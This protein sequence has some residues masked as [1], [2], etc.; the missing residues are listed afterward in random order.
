MKAELIDPEQ[1]RLLLEQLPAIVWST[2]REL[3]L[4]TSL[5]AGLSVLGLVPNQVLG[6]SLFE[7]FGTQDRDFPPI[8]AHLQALEG[9]PVHTEVEW[10]GRCYE[11]YVEPLRGTGR[12]ILGVI[13]VALDV[14]QRKRAELLQKALYR[15]SETAATAQDMPAFYAALHAIVGELMYARNFYI[16]L[17]DESGGL[18]HFP[19]FVD[20]VDSPPQPRKP[21]HGL[22]EYVL[23]HGEPLLLS[24]ESFRELVA[25]QEVDL[26]GADSWDWLG[27]PLQSREWTFGVLAVQSYSEDV[28]YSEQDKEVLNFVSQ[29]ISSALQRRR[30]EEEREQSLSLLRAT[31][32]ST[33][34]GILVVD[35]EGRMVSFNRRFVGMWRIPEEIVASR[36][37]DRALAFVLDQLLDPEGFLI[38]VRELYDSPEAQSFDVLEFKDGRVFER[39]S[40]SQQVAGASLGRVW[41]FRDVTERHKLEEQLRQA[42]K[43]EAIGRLAGGVAHDFNNLLTVIN[44]RSE[45]LLERLPLNDPV[46]AEI[47]E[48]NQAGDRAADLTRQLVAFSRRQMLRPRLVS[49][50]QV[51]TEMERLLR[52]VI[53]E[54]IQLVTRLDPELGLTRADSSQIEQLVLNLAANARDAMPEG[55]QLLIT[56]ANVVV[57]PESARRRLDIGPGAYVEL[58]VSDT[59]VGMN[60]EVLQRLFEPFFSTKGPGKGTGLGLA[61]V[62]G[63]VKQSGGDIAVESR[64]GAGSGFRIYLPRVEGTL[65]ASSPVGAQPDAAPPR[66][67]ILLVEDEVAVRRL[68][69]QFLRQ[70]GYRVLEAGDGQEAMDLVRQLE[71]PVDLLLTDVVMPRVGGAELARQ[72]LESRPGLQVVYMSGYT[73]QAGSLPQSALQK[74]E[75]VLVLKP[76]STEL[77]AARLREILGGA[78][79]PN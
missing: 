64:L 36:D 68:F 54:H 34:D 39:Y 20:E 32:D 57:G 74:G 29:H 63:V 4:T 14:T 15:I 55:G 78:A 1:A 25:R 19:Y 8:R 53:G 18:I 10:A 42:H 59:G 16:A 17:H 11:T 72:L 28:R 22:T 38:K 61:T 69:G 31:L 13:G 50:N 73:E 46:R 7:Y 62:Y 58:A 6:M 71:E 52:R 37:D 21:G 35:R 27:V 45:L 26:V 24:P 76:L 23:S 51:V 49:L 66:K 70:Q 47:E 33:A 5:G 43:M 40:Q 60:D 30:A 65:E 67:T 48:I 12:E 75:P 3:R 2:D 79:D 77:L 56:T 44:G 9:E 41:S